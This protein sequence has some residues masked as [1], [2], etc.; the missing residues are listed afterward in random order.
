MEVIVCFEDRG[1]GGDAVG[2]EG[3]VR[4]FAAV[5]GDAVAFGEMGVVGFPAD[6]GDQVVEDAELG[7][8]S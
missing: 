4:R 6:V 8:R 3:R 1:A 5:V 2:C 7:L